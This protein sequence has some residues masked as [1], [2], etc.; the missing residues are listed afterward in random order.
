M[1][2]VTVTKDI[3]LGLVYSFRGLVHLSSCRGHGGMQANHDILIL[4]LPHQ[5]VRIPVLCPFPIQTFSYSHEFIMKKR[6]FQKHKSRLE[7]ETWQVLWS[8]LPEVKSGSAPQGKHHTFLIMLTTW[9]GSEWQGWSPLTNARFLKITLK[10][11]WNL[12]ISYWPKN[13]NI[14]KMLIGPAVGT[15]RHCSCWLW[16]VVEF[17]RTDNNTH[18]GL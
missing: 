4:D 7:S 10:Q 8:P 2:N 6:I 3:Y 16:K 12:K 1:G 5:S 11:R 14:W 15:H 13:A 18:P 17:C 9:L